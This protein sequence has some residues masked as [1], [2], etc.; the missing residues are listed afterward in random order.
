MEGAHLIVREGSTNLVAVEGDLTRQPVEAIV[1]AANVELQH[2]G[3][4][5][6]A[7]VRTGGRVIQEESDEWVRNHGPLASG[8][9]A[10]T[11]GGMLLAAHVIHVAGPRYQPGAPNAEL[12][13][14]AIHAALDAAV[15]IEARTV[16][17]PAVSAGT[18]GYPPI[19]ATGVIVRAAVN[20]IGRQPGALDELRF[21]GF[22]RTTA[23]HFADHL[24]ALHAA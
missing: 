13:A 20:W 4:V 9:A 21:V 6:R 19:E 24:Q 17:L 8:A 3:G 5:A 7:I 15:S 11:T 23:G 14:L 22:D 10:V 18:F 2:G 16:A 1:N 12:L